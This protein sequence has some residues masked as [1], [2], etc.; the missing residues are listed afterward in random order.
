MASSVRKLLIFLII[1]FFS[2]NVWAGKRQSSYTGTRDFC[3]T[4]KSEDGTVANTQCKDLQVSDGMLS[5]SG[6]IFLLRSGVANGG[7]TSMTT[8]D[9][10]VNPS[11][12]FVR[13]AIS[14]DPAFQTG[15]LANGEKGQ[16]LTI[17]ITEVDG[18]GTFT[19]TPT[20]TTG[21]TSM[22]FEGPKD[23]VTLL[24]VDDTVGWVPIT[25]GSVQMVD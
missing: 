2:A 9:T 5:K 15:T 11:F 14:S 4:V 6:N 23:L 20:T 10:A 7:A 24:Y 3:L 21:F 8:S 18:N 25:Y 22:I 12:T 16:I 17:L 13:K 1:L 19:L